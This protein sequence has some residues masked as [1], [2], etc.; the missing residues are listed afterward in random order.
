[1]RR[2]DLRQPYPTFTAAPA[3]RAPAIRQRR[4]L[5]AWPI[6]ATLALALAVL[7]HL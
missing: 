3:T 4:T 7:S 5:N 6:L 1:M 2:Q